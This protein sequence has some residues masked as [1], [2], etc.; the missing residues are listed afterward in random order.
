MAES[1][2]TGCAGAEWDDPANDLCFSASS[3]M[4]AAYFF[5]PGVSRADYTTT[6]LD[7]TTIDVT[8]LQSLIDS[9]DAKLV[10]GL[11]IGFDAP[12]IITADSF[13]ACTTEAPVN[14]DRTFTYKDRK[15]NETMRRFYSSLGFLIGGMLIHE[16]AAGR[17]TS[18]DAVITFA[19]GRVSPEGDE[20]QR[21]E[22]TGTYKQ[23]AEAMIL[24]DAA[25]WDLV[26]TPT[27]GS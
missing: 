10:T 17:A 18:I 7:V 25:V 26:P 22:Y 23:V 6:A 24:A 11:R 21:W 13:M 9:G 27:S 19:G 2:F 14:Y 5:K 8:K 16:C 15:V 12:S 3:G 20:L 1:I 4:D